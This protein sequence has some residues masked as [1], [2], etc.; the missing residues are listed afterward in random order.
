MHP[1]LGGVIV[2]GQQFL[3]VVGDRG[4]VFGVPDLGQVLRRAPSTLAILWNQQRCSGVWG[5][6][7]PSA[8]QKPS[9]PSAD[10]QYGGA[11]A[12]ALAVAQRSAQDSVDSR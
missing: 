4:L 6:P 10:R 11:H 8:P 12:A 9:A 2:E 7:S 5:N 1:V 3:Q